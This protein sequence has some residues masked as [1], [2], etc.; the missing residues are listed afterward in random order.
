[1]IK[2]NLEINK[3][4]MKAV[5]I[6]EEVHRALKKLAVNENTNI[7]NLVAILINNYRIYKN[8]QRSKNVA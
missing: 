8:E 2:E 1:M 5:W 7:H 3:D 4:E 6:P